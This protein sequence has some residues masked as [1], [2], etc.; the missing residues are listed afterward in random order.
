MKTS[1]IAACDFLFFLAL[2][3]IPNVLLAQLVQRGSD[4][5]GAAANDNFGFSTSMPD[6]STLAVGA[7]YANS[8][9]TDAGQ[10][11]IYRFKGSNWVQKGTGINGEFSFDYSGY[12][13][14]MG[15]S[16]T[17]AIGAISNNGN[18]SRSGHVR[19]FRW[20]GGA[21]IQKGSDID[22][23]SSL[24]RS[25]WT[26]SMPDSNTVAI[27]SPYN[28]G[29]GSASGHVRV[30][31]WV[32]QKWVQKG[33]DI[34]GE[35]SS[36]YSG[37][38]VSMPDSNTVA[39]G[40]RHNAGNGMNAGHVRIYN[41]NGTSW[42]Q[43]GGDIDGDTLGDQCGISVSMPDSN[44]FATGSYLNDEYGTKSGHV[45][46]FKWNG[47]SWIQKGLSIGGSSS[48]DESGFS[49][50]MPDS[51]TVAIGARQN[52][53]NG[54]SSGQARIFRWNGSS[55]T[56]K[57]IDLYGENA[58]DQSG[59][60]LNMP[61]ANTL[62]V[63][64]PYN[65]DAGSGSGQSRVFQF[66]PCTLSASIPTSINVSCLGNNDGSI[67]VTQVGGTGSFTYNWSNN[68]NTIDST[69]SSDTLLNLQAGTYNV[70]VT[71]LNG[72]SD[73]ANSTISEPIEIVT[74][75][76]DTVACDSF[77][78]SQDGTSYYSSGI[79]DDTLLTNTNSCDSIIRIDVT[80][81]ISTFAIDSVVACGEYTWPKNN[82][83]FL[84]TNENFIKVDS[85]I[86]TNSSACDSITYLY[87][88]ILELDSSIIISGDTLIASE[89]GNN[90]SYQWIDCQDSTI[91]IG[92][93]SQLFVAQ[94][95]GNY[96]A[97]LTNNSTINTTVCRDTS[98]CFSLQLVNL[99]ENK[100]K[101]IFN[102]SPNPSK[103]II[104]LKLN[105]TV[106]QNETIQIFDLQGRLVKETSI[107]NQQLSINM[108]NLEKGIY[109]LR[110]RKQFAKFILQ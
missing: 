27:G 9:G 1:S 60:R 34:D 86:T 17:I 37:G 68:M 65:T 77:F 91:I 99:N 87:L 66:S 81:S 41:W 8:N 94:Q 33:G 46:I 47:S 3:V 42:L 75:L 2:L 62:C 101:K 6:A 79:Y 4:L 19:I 54:S 88:Q 13:I 63:S 24:N 95:N 35:S 40:A 110:F 7:P 11:N 30:Y 38:A 78:W 12:A 50:S 29:N 71:D 89:S 20:D 51:N 102:L 109:F 53:G 28:S 58:G 85:L 64:T 55:W 16:S 14:S 70:T 52:D 107:E 74:L 73:T 45:R 105:T 56:Q 57:G 84:T 106:N 15:D 104:N 44:T 90:V 100:Q 36:D 103:G 83:L 39:I 22:G 69:A 43:K 10:V 76:A 59:F 92:A 25:G 48:L 26:V 93:D 23:E 32:N 97:I 98:A 21:W 49:V 108:E 72:C 31:Y 82:N 18:G 5:N 80:I 67:I 61:D 96:A